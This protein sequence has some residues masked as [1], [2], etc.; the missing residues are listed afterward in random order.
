M[1]NKADQNCTNIISIKYKSPEK[2]K[3]IFANFFEE[4]EYLIILTATEFKTYNSVFERN[5]IQD[6]VEQKV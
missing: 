2:N 1:N 4:R 3:C 6:K 5:L